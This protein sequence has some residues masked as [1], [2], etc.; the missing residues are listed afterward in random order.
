MSIVGILL[1]VLFVLAG[2]QDPAA[3]VVN[4]GD[5]SFPPQ[6]P[7]E[8][9]IKNP[10]TIPELPGGFTYPDAAKVVT[11]DA[12][13]IALAFNGGILVADTSDS[14]G[15]S[16][17]QPSA[18]GTG[19]AYAQDGV[20][21][22]IWAGPGNFDT[23]AGTGANLGSIVVP[24][25][26]TLFIGVPLAFGDPAT[27]GNYFTSISV[28]DM[29]ELPLAS[30]Q[31][32]GVGGAN[33]T[34]P[35]ATKPG[36]L[37]ILAGAQITTAT[38]GS[39][40][41]GGDLEIHQGGGI[42]VS[43][44]TPLTFT[45]GSKAVV[46]GSIVTN[47]ANTFN[48][49]L[50]IKAGGS[51]NAT[52]DL[53]T[54]VFADDVTVAGSLS[55]PTGSAVIVTFNGNLT[56]ETGATL[57]L[58]K[59]TTFNKKAT[60][61]GSL[62]TGT[63]SVS[64][65]SSGWLAIEASGSLSGSWGAFTT[66]NGG[67]LFILEKAI[68]ATEPKL[69]E[70]G[71]VTIASA[72]GV[73]KTLA[74]TNITVND[75]ADLVWY[76]AQDSI[77]VTAGVTYSDNFADETVP[78]VITKG[79]KVILDSSV[80]QI[81]NLELKADGYLSIDAVVLGKNVTLVGSNTGA[82]PNLTLTNGGPTFATGTTG[83]N[84]TI[85]DTAGT[86]SAITLTAAPLTSADDATVIT[87]NKNAS[88]TL[89]TGGTDIAVNPKGS[90]KLLAGDAGKDNGGK[91]TTLA[92]STGS[93][94]EYLKSL[95]IGAEAGFTAAGTDVTFEA[96]TIIKVGANGL[97]SAPDTNQT[98]LFNTLNIRIGSTGDVGGVDPANNN[99][100]AG[101]GEVYLPAWEVTNAKQH[102]FNQLLAIREVGVLSITD[103]IKTSGYN[104]KTDDAAAPTSADAVLTIYDNTVGITLAGNLT[105]DRNLNL[106]SGAKLIGP[107][108]VY[109][110]TINQGK[111]IYA[112]DKPVLGGSSSQNLA[113]LSI[114]SGGTLTAAADG[115]IVNSAAVTVLPGSKVLV[116]GQFGGGGAIIAGETDGLLTLAAHADTYLK[117]GSI[118]T[119]G[120]ELTGTPSGY[121]ATVS[122]DDGG[123]LSV[124]ATSANTSRIVDIIV[125]NGGT[126][127]ASAA[128]LTIDTGII[129]GILKA[130]S[131]STIVA[132]TT[133]SAANAVT[134]VTGSFTASGAA[135]FKGTAASSVVNL[136]G[137]I[138]VGKGL[139]EYDT[140]EFGGSTLTGEVLFNGDDG[141][142]NI[143]ANGSVKSGSLSTKGT[144]GLT[145]GASGATGTIY[146]I[147]SAPQ[148]LGD[149]TV[150]SGTNGLTEGTLTLGADTTLALKAELK[151]GLS[152]A[153]AATLA[154][155]SGKITLANANA[156]ISAQAEGSTPAN[157]GTITIGSIPSIV[158]LASSVNVT[159]S[160]T[161]GETGNVA[162]TAK[163]I[164]VTGTG[165]G[166]DA[167][168]GD[169]GELKVTSGVASIEGSAS[170][171]VTLS[172][173]STLYN[174]D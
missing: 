42:S 165:S 68:G 135:A 14:T 72:T 33:V 170:G 60:I 93:V 163:D 10:D 114:A 32:S 38:Y 64:I 150:I 174:H 167:T 75:Y 162:G 129:N 100:P 25:G 91:F 30:I 157:K 52:A 39:I 19:Y 146:A 23:S 46:Y 117:S 137:K 107:S 86:A 9:T 62:A 110:I 40:T 145:I 90:I 12:T 113:V 84:L 11:G 24:P 134:T 22:V 156:K 57:T 65:G 139:S 4:E 34:G 154:V 131:A 118:E 127:D 143:P 44:T 74:L 88:L 96:L 70:N 94:F 29:G 51:V 58:Q 168:K 95:S 13:A 15:G 7:T 21:E 106:A 149:T 104:V 16:V 141:I 26:K 89:G 28:S 152:T 80:T 108:A 169:A 122:I 8:V 53:G 31:A 128:A 171:L 55:L 54:L 66:S 125:A 92:N 36:K 69:D 102:A 147:G 71:R 142:I 76:A 164:F 50:D 77:T 160:Y 2:C 17:V 101:A 158:G 124:G 98:D 81:G 35:K 119:S 136:T 79:N 43:G 3:P 73:K 48:G 109:Q 6:G 20:D 173:A 161:T 82:N 115:E 144:G 123:T 99:A 120:T 97:L 126:I 172:S 1:A 27:P 105:V 130:T 49:T 37:V 18:P 61:N 153:S 78:L 67:D 45:Q 59:A 116:P 155:G 63:V 112:N 133:T 56:V 159:T 111:G 138:K 148:A 41:V 83:F 140:A 132:T 85:G 5:I 87:V 121:K 151:V 166:G 47:S 103:L